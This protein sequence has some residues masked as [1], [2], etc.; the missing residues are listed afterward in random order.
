MRPSSLR[1]LPVLL[2]AAVLVCGPAAAEDHEQ[3]RGTYYRSGFVSPASLRLDGF[4]HVYA[5]GPALNFATGG[6]ATATETAELAQLR[7]HCRRNGVKLIGVVVGGSTAFDALANAG[8]R[9]GLANSLAQWCRESRL[10]GV[11]IDFEHP[12]NTT[13]IANYS[14]FMSQVRAALGPRAEVSA[15]VAQIL[16]IPSVSPSIV[17]LSLD[18]LNIMSYDLGSPDHASWQKALNHLY[19]H[20]DRGILP[21]RLSQGVPFYGVNYDAYVPGGWDHQRSWAG[22]LA[23][24]RADNGGAD[25][26]PSLNVIRGYYFNGVDLIRAKAKRSLGEVGGVFTWILDHDVPTSG[27]SLRDAMIAGAEEGQATL[28]GFEYPLFS[29]PSASYQ[30]ANAVLA[31][32]L[33]RSG[34]TYGA[35]AT[36][37]FNGNPWCNATLRSKAMAP[38]AVPS[39]AVVDFD[40][41]VP[42][43]G[44]RFGVVYFYFYDSSG[45]IARDL[46]GGLSASSGWK[47]LSFARNSGSWELLQ[48]GFD[49]NQVTGFQILLDGGNAGSTVAPWTTQIVLDSLCLRYPGVSRPLR[50]DHDG[51]DDGVPDHASAAGD[52]RWIDR[53]THPART[54]PGM[55][56]QTSGEPGQ[57]RWADAAF[58]A[59]RRVMRWDLSF[60][61][62]QWGTSWIAS[63]RH[64]A[65]ALPPEATLHLELDVIT[66]TPTGVLV[67]DLID[68][69][70]NTAR[71]W[72]YSSGR[73]SG[74]TIWDLR[75]DQFAG[76]GFD[77]SRIVGWRL[78]FQGTEAATGP[79]PG[80]IE[81]ADIAW[82]RLPAGTAMPGLEGDSDGDGLSD[83]AEDRNLNGQADPGETR[84]DLADSDGDGSDDGVEWLSGTDALDPASHLTL[85][86][87]RNPSGDQFQLRWPSR[88]G[89]RYQVES[90]ADLQ[91][92]EEVGAVITAGS[93]T[94][95]S[96]TLVP[97]SPAG[98]DSS[99]FYRV[100]LLD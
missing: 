82:G 28:D 55:I 53:F 16:G 83:A 43:A 88:P 74:L 5:M 96:S 89:S 75:V 51:D 32:T 12:R 95:F 9:A 69:D 81:L 86:A 3:I 60:S 23:N 99:L 68:A 24:Y 85:T 91:E 47:H 57:L 50:L 48:G 20:R 79:F 49:W 8:L 98:A 7:T 76:T 100:R 19:W 13:D 31:P 25:P 92:W 71:H 84:A 46:R 21:N 93:G 40:L 29:S 61:G 80:R 44:A 62:A 42:P 18:R 22:L 94:D 15:A 77:R 35:E 73:R 65:M 67:F 70:G 38:F 33:T 58:G 6:W 17:N 30:L 4:T 26:P 87:V 90:S 34:G 11:D 59:T 2:L 14:T 45:R 56:Y 97:A 36:L 27:L 41:L 66:P 10:D 52:I 64:P 63:P 39:D 78:G 1:Q 37:F 54:Q 72:D